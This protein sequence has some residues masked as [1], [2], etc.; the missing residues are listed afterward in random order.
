MTTFPVAAGVRILGEVISWTCSGVSVTQSALVTA[1]EEAGLDP[2]VARELAP[3][4]AFTRACKHLSDQ[5]IIRQVAEDEA[6]V[7]FQFTSETRSTDR[8]TYEL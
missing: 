6:T 5:R 3:K 1:L 8:I 7:T 4:H 2:A